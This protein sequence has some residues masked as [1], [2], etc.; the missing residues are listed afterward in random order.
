MIANKKNLV[1]ANNNGNVKEKTSE[2]FDI[3]PMLSNVI[4]RVQIWRN[5]LEM[6]KTEILLKNMQQMLNSI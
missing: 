4:L 6:L 2:D 1:V 5:S 3:E